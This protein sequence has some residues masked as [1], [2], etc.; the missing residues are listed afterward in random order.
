MEHCV[1]AF[2][3]GFCA[4]ERGIALSGGQKQRLAIARALLKD[5]TILIMDE[6][7]SALDAQAEKA[8]QTALDQ[9]ACGRTVLLIAH[10]LSTIV[11]ADIIYVLVNGKIHEVCVCVCVCVCA[12][13]TFAYVINVQLICLFHFI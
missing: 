4:G 3:G 6:A 12:C 13:N 2:F 9:A 8:V 7:T 5:P 10:R 1:R 11:N